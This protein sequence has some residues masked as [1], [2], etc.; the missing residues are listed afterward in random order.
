MSTTITQDDFL[1]LRTFIEELCG[2]SLGDNK[3]Y[4]I[5]SRLAKLMAL[6]GCDSFSEFYHLAKASEGPELKEKIIDAMTTNETLWF[7]DEHPYIILKEVMLPRMAESLK[8]G[9]RDRIRIWSA[10][11]STG[12]EAYSMAVTIQEFC[13][14]TPGVTP[15][16]FEIIG[17]DISASALFLA[18]AGRYD[19]LA[20]NRGMSAEMAEKYFTQ[21]GM[22][23][24]IN[25]DIKKMV[26]FKKFNLQVSPTTLGRFDI[27]FLR[28]VAI[29]F[30]D[31]F[32][33]GL[34]D[35]LTNVTNRPGYLII[36]AVETLRGID[37]RYT[38][39]QH[40]NG[41]YYHLED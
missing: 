7:R 30:S 28:Y 35:R 9:A 21:D 14:K 2:I 39:K 27:V 5:E 10:A 18:T 19:Q 11:S 32:K 20:M 4:L 25:D 23:W 8:S 12:Q 33:A 34:I 36:G 29:Y 26:T 40:Q 16:Q 31:E 17:T 41:I 22:V 13:N 3:A 15:D 1:L 37:S 24:I 6:N 38:H